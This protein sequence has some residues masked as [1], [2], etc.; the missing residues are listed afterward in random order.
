MRVWREGSAGQ[1]SIR[2]IRRTTAMTPVDI[3]LIL[4]I[5]I[6]FAAAV[7]HIRRKKKSGAGTCS[8]GCGGCSFQEECGSSKKQGAGH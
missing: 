7:F 3:I 6:A 5:A 2:K 1:R 8:C 4:V